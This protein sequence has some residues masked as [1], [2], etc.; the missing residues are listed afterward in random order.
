MRLNRFLAS[1]GV[2][3]RRAADALIAAGKVRINARLARLGDTVD[4]QRDAV[5]VDGE[6]VE[7]KPAAVETI[8]LNKP[9]GVITTMH[10]ERGRKSV[11]ALLPAGKRL[12]PV[13]RLDAATT[14]VLLCTNDGTLADFLLRAGHGVPRVYRVT[15]RGPVFQ[16]AIAALGG[17]DG[18]TARDGTVTF[19]LTLY[20]GRN[21]QV[22]RLCA[23]QGLEIVS[24]VRTQFGPVH[25]G[26]LALGR[27]RA[28]T[29]AERDALHRLQHGG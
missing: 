16:R 22:R 13:G 4:P 29:R 20:E 7:P 26:K 15:V 5:T 19:S 18:R 27:T 14:G 23:R 8:V 1:C 25:L 11:A 3:S 21:R 6:K 9:A 2:G 17:R 10:D 28:L 24:L 12:Y